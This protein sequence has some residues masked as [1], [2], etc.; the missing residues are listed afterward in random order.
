MSNV[1]KIEDG[2][3]EFEVIFENKITCTRT[4]HAKDEDEAW[5]LAQEVVDQMYSVDQVIVK[6]Q[7]IDDL[8]EEDCEGWEVESVSEM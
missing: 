4:I 1:A 8:D 5:K 3:P 2:M 6:G 7:E